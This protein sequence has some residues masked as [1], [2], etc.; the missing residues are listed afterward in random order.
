V[1]LAALVDT[2]GLGPPSYEEVHWSSDVDG[3]LGTGYELTADL[4]AGEH[5]VTVTI[6]DGLG[7]TLSVRAIIVVGGRPPRPMSG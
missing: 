4:S 7:S 1:H 6:P 2:R 3:D 5:T